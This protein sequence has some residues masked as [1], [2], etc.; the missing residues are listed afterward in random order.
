MSAIMKA[1]V[2]IQ[3]PS[4]H[5]KGGTKVEEHEERKKSS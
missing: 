3:A 4:Y 5:Y 1:L 2:A